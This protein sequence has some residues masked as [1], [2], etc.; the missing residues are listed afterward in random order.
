MSD[1]QYQIIL[2]ILIVFFLYVL[3]RI[4]VRSFDRYVINFFI[5]FESLSM[6][7]FFQD[8]FLPILSFILVICSFLNLLIIQQGN[9]D[10]NLNNNLKIRKL[11]K[12]SFIFGLLIIFSYLFLEYLILDGNISIHGQ[13]IIIFGIFLSINNQIPDKYFYENLFSFYFL[14]ILLSFFLLPHFFEMFLESIGKNPSYFKNN[15]IIV[16]LL[17]IPLKIIL[18]LLGFTV[19]SDGLYLYY[20]DLSSNT[21]S[22][23]WIAT[24]CS[25]YYSIIIFCSAFVSYV[26]TNGSKLDFNSLLLIKIGIL[27][28][29]CANLLRMTVI[30]LVGHYYGGDA[31]EW[32]HANIGWLIFIFW[33]FLFFK[34][35][36][37]WPL[38]ELNTI[39]KYGH[40]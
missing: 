18:T 8:K 21:I 33:I 24:S 35:I 26:F 37:T 22:A 29:Y 34:L 2:T 25:G 23:V 38:K 11:R 14:S 30:V 1:N 6:L 40:K 39:N 9:N 7:L 16:P 4:T 36:N 27:F 12:S 3:S 32:T 10:F 20:E 19:W 5:F 13:L 17:I 15:V 31:L 28:A